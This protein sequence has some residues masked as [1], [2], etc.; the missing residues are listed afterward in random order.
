MKKIALLG[1]TGSIGTSTLEVIRRF[2]K[3]FEVVG[4]SAHCN[5]K[6]LKKQVDE[7]SPK[8][9]VI[10]DEES[11][12]KFKESN[13]NFKQK[14]L[15][16]WEGLGELCT[17][18]EVN[19]IVN[20]LVGAIGLLP[21]LKTLESKKDLAI[22]NKEAL[23]MAGKFL[24]DIAK[25]NG[26]Q[27]IPIDSEHS[28]LKQCLLAG[29]RKEVRR[30]ILTA[31]GGPFYKRK[32]KNFKK[33]TV[34]EALSHPTWNMGKKITIDSATLMNKG[35]EVIEAHWLF[36][37]PT[38]RI[39]VIIHS[40]SIVH[41]MVEYVDGSVIAQ[42]SYPDMKLPIQ[43]ALFCPQ[44]FPAEHKTLDLSE[45][46][47]LSFD[48]VDKDKFPC[49]ELAYVALK[50]GGTA[51]AVLNATNEV[52]VEA[53][54]NKQIS[55]VEIAELIKSILNSHQ[56]QKEPNLTQILDADKWAREEAYKIIGS[57]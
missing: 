48:K 14:L 33:I 27:I 35:L 22:A 19:L 49:L 13:P 28:A 6:V 34:E 26:V 39:D 53:F 55:F 8:V 4:L 56:I 23:V 17:S 54:L 50:M 20:A 29:E 10:T 41:S 42:I 47:G 38:E 46:Q 3:E 25:K 52:A 36:G 5:V 12:N 43:Y 1:S 9:V 31:S 45:V 32:I 40:Q 16:G 21:S 57:K 2:P 15:Y 7:F 11:Y 37:I 24:T 44:R 18:D 51:P 30:L